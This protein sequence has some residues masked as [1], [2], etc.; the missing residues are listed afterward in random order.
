MARRTSSVQPSRPPLLLWVALALIPAHA[1][2]ADRQFSIVNS[3]AF[4]VWPAVTNWN[5]G[6]TYTGV[7][8]WEAAAGSKK[9]VTVPEGWNGRVCASSPSLF[10]APAGRG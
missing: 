1:L 10:H 4:I 9:T 5:E 7:R 6:K 8:G 3:C 2:A